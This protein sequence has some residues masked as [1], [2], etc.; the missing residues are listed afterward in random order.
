[1]TFQTGKPMVLRLNIKPESL[2]ALL[3][4]L[5]EWLTSLL[6]ILIQEHALISL[7][8]L[9]LAHTW[10]RV[11]VILQFGDLVSGIRGLSSSDCG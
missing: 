4:L 10:C 9:F 8:F 1:M 6:S 11:S 5:N 3:V 7:G 2:H